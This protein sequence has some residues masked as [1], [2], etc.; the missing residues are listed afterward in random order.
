VISYR[1]SWE[2]SKEVLEYLIINRSFKGVACGKCKAR[3]EKG[4][5]PAQQCGIDS[6]Q[7]QVVVATKFNG[8][9]LVGLVGGISAISFKQFFGWAGSIYLPITMTV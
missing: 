2:Q 6:V 3:N 1:N 7:Y 8:F 4:N 5:S 9:Q